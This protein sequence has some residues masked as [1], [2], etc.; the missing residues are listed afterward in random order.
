MSAYVAL[1]TGF[2]ASE[3]Q[4]MDLEDLARWSSE[5]SSLRKEEQRR[6]KN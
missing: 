4:D 3:I 6:N 1:A 5:I 2:G